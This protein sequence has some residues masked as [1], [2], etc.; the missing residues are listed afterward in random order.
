MLGSILSDKFGRKT[1]VFP[2][3]VLTYVC[4]FISAFAQ[5]YWVFALF[6]ALVGVGV[7][8]YVG[9]LA[10]FKNLGGTK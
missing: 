3:A 9:T 5:T 6:R 1:V 8:K 7:G 4:G 10:N 2:Y